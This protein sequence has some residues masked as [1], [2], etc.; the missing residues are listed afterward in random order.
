MGRV[1]AVKSSDVKNMPVYKSDIASP[2]AYVFLIEPIPTTSRVA[3]SKLSV[4]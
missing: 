3:A 2:P 4:P 1:E